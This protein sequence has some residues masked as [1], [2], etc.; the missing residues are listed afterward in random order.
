MEGAALLPPSGSLNKCRGECRHARS[1]VCLWWFV[2][3]G[4]DDMDYLG[5]F[6][7]KIGR[8]RSEISDIQELNQQ[9]RRDGGNGTGCQVAHGQRSERLQ[10]IQHE[11]MQLA[12][13]G[14]GVVSTEQ[15]KENHH[16]RPHLVE[17]K[18]AA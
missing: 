11:L 7:A 14:R 2:S 18:R 6:R 10:G 13:L 3:K 5:V 1:L 4:I 9:F 12:D 17:R 8:L 16:S 15:M